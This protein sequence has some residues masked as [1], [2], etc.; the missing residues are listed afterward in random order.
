MKNYNEDYYLLFANPDYEEY[1][2]EPD[3]S[4][5]N[6]NYDSEELYFGQKPLIFTAE[7]PNLNFASSEYEIFFPIG[8]I[9]VTDSLKV[10][11]EEG[12][13]GSKF[14]PAIVKGE[15]KGIR[16]DVWALNIFKPLDCWDRNKSVA[17]YPEGVKSIQ[18]IDVLPSI[19]SFHLS[20]EVLD[21]I[22]ENERL[23]FV[24]DNTD[25]TNIFVHKRIVDIF[26]ANNV[27]GVNF[28]KVSQYRFGMEF[29]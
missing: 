23:I 11:L 19:K 18:G 15:D 28:F 25:V 24:M 22:P 7:T 10:K 1:D 2:I 21:E 6:R 3:D 17:V 13:Y 5:A 16:E 12:L 29:V 26:S 4:S 27:K 14:Y 8:S 9:V 20:H